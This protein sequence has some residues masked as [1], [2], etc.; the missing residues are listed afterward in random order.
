MR[1]EHL[2]HREKELQASSRVGV[3]NELLS[4]AHGP[5]MKPAAA[6]DCGSLAFE[7]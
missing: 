6:V 4:V 2:D 3:L 1:N 5:A 7:L